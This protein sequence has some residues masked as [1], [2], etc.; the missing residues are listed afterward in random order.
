MKQR[1]ADFEPKVK[2]II[3]S[4][5]GYRCSYPGCDESTVGPGAGPNDVERKGVAAHIFAAS[6]GAKAPRGTGGLSAED[7]STAANGI[8]LCR[9]H[10]WLADYEKGKNYPA[11]MLQAWKALQESRI[12][13]EL[14]KSSVSQVFW[15]ESVE[16]GA[17]PLFV[18]GSTLELGK[19]TLLIGPNG[20]GK[21]ALCEWLS[22][23]SGSAGDLD[24]WVTDRLGLGV[25]LQLKLRVPDLTVFSLNFK[26]Y[27]LRSEYQGKIV[28]DVSHV[29]R[30]VYLEDRPARRRFE[31][32][33]EY[34]AR[35]WR[36][37]VYQ[38]S[39]IVRK[40]ASPKYGSIEAVKFT[41]HERSEDNEENEPI[42]SDVAEKR[43]GRVP[44]QLEVKIGGND[45][46]LPY[47]LLSGAEHSQILIAG[48]MVLADQYGEHMGALL[49][50]DL[51]GNMDDGLVESFAELLQ[52]SELNFQTI[53]VAHS[54]RPKVNW[55]GWSVAHL[56]KEN[57]AQ[58]RVEQEWVRQTKEDL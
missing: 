57:G 30:V 6:E 52:S 28:P 31:D 29:L 33:V 45:F 20:L 5:A 19:V 36:V 10:S 18:T 8:W 40:L 14:Q 50:L 21:S 27:S 1:D 46:F 7:R 32:D 15:L 37:H 12:A 4:R 56:E 34:L 3:A 44:M 38:V 42:P 54:P 47:G 39:E 35:A 58:V 11:S 13:R 9:D 53:L 25:N 22:A 2:E 55:S 16:L 49:L 17:N 48:A 24:R 43:D 41:V 23:C 51:G 26:D